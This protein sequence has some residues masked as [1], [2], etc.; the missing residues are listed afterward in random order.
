[1]LIQ[2]ACGDAGR[3]LGLRLKWPNDVYLVDGASRIKIGGVL[4]QSTVVTGGA[5]SVSGRPFRVVAGIGINVLNS[6]PTT[7]LR[8]AVEA[9]VSRSAACA[10]SRETLLATFCFHFEEL[11][12]ELETSGFQPLVDEYLSQWMH[13]GQE[14]EV[15][16]EDKSEAKQRA[17]IVG[18]SHSGYLLA[19]SLTTSRE[20]ELHPDGNSLDMMDGLIYTKR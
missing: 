9:R 1:M 19:K 16:I 4:C 7:C 20:L 11:A 12:E 5:G 18:L 8:D 17:V 14:V 10:I 6:E 13:S 3:E 15:Q 2:V